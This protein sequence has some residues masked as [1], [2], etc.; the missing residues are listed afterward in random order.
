MQILPYEQCKEACISK[1]DYELQC[2]KLRSIN[3]IFPL[4]N[5]RQIFP[6]VVGKYKNTIYIVYSY[7][8]Y[9]ECPEELKELEK[10]DLVE[11]NH[12]GLWIRL[13]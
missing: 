3:G 7:Y 8:N 10:H 12:N 13:K 1:E 2:S 5:I 9:M 4:P 6:S 11:I